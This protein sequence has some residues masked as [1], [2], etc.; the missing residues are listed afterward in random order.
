MMSRQ[1]KLFSLLLCIFYALYQESVTA[2]AFEEKL[3]LYSEYLKNA[4]SGKILGMSY[5]NEMI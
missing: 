4:F 1:L 5:M 2:G 3:S